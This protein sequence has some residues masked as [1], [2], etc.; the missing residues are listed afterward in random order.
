MDATYSTSM[1]CQSCLTK[2]GPKLDA[3]PTVER[4]S[5]D[6]DD[7]RKLLRVSTANGA[8][9]DVV[10]GLLDEAGF[11]AQRIDGAQPADP[12]TTAQTT[13]ADG[14]PTRQESHH[15]A[16]AGEESPSA[17]RLANYKPLALVLAYV[18]GAAGLTEAAHP[19]FDPMRAMSYFMGY[20]FIGFAFFK[21]LDIPAFADAFGRYDIVA[22]RSRAYALWYP[23]I[24][25]GLGLLYVSLAAPVVANTLTIVVMLVGLVGVVR[26]VR[27]GQTIQCA[28]LGTV[29]N[30]PMSVVT[31]VENSAM[32]LMAAGMLV[33]LLA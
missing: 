12:S 27:S 14:G 31:I 7:Q 10:V 21:L 2:V 22:K 3:E 30:L 20:F 24:E 23:W 26:T 1:K 33:A 8:D 18:L 11:S 16:G 17:L 5:A 25:L 28:C 19:G 9:P 13:E 32:A 4:W 29:F 6:L 15:H